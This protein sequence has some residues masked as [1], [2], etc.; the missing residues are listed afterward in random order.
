MCGES[1]VAFGLRMMAGASYTDMVGSALGLI[2]KSVQSTYNLFHKFV[3]WV[4]AT[5]SFPLIGILERLKGG[6]PEQK[7]ADRA[8]LEDLSSAFGEDS[9]GMFNG[10][11]GAIDGLAIKMLCRSIKLVKDPGAYFCRKNFH[12]LNVQAVCD[13]SKIFLGS[14]LATRDLPMTQVLW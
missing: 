7:E 5:Y 4:W 2:F 8:K 11:F 1:V 12:A 9:G 10:W 3:D 6:T 14:A 13:R